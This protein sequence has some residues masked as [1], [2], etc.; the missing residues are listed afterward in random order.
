MLTFSSPDATGRRARFERA[1]RRL[2]RLVLASVLVS[3]VGCELRRVPDGAWRLRAPPTRPAAAHAPSV[4][5]PPRVYALDPEALARAKRR[6]RSGDPQIR[7]AYD[8]LVREA[9]VALEVPASS[10]MDKRRVP[11]SGDKHDYM[12]MAPYWWPDSAKP[13]GLPYVRRDGERNPEFR[14]DYDAPR[15]AAV[16]GAVT[17]LALAYYFT[18]DEQYARRAALLLRT[19]FLDPAT[20]MNPHLRYGQG[21]P[22]ITQGRAAGII[23]TRGLVGV[24]DAIGMIERSPSWTAADERGMAQWLSAYLGWLRSSP[25]GKQERSARNNHGTWYD[26][27]VATLALFTDDTSLAR[28]TLADART[29]RIGSQVMADGRQPYELTR[30]RSFAYSVMNLEGLCRLAELGR[31]V[32]VDLWSYRSPRGGSIRKAL[33]YLAPYADPQRKW[34][35][36]QITPT[37]PDLLV[38]P[39]AQARLAYH[40]AR[41]DALLRQIPQD[42]VRSHRAQLLYPEPDSVPAAARTGS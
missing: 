30:T 6:V 8:R 16:T 28:S 37:E 12:S 36:R 19:W 21:I 4:A 35:G 24:V 42:A 38:S 9:A 11:P 20:R 18:D 13:G 25:I 23:E 26:A 33:D 34:A 5:A 17:T 3:V 7:S 14:D 41:Y 2:A 39:L 1:V 31:H 22:G 32:G 40:D 27:Q 29:R 15:L 10:V